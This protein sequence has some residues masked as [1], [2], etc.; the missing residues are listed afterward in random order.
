MDY[1]QNNRQTH[2]PTHVETY[3]HKKVKNQQKI[4]LSVVNDGPPDTE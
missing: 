4:K 1:K 2:W 3:E